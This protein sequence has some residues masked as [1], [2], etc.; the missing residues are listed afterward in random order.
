[1]ADEKITLLKHLSLLAMRCSAM[2]TSKIS[3][4][5]TAITED[6]IE[7]DEAKQDKITGTAGDKVVIGPDGNVTTEVS[8]DVSVETMTQAEYDALP[9]KD[10]NTLY[11]LTDAD[12]D[13]ASNVSV[14]T[15]TIGTAWTEDSETGVKS[16]TVAISGI[17][18]DHTAKVDCVFA[19]NKDSDGYA[20]FVEQQN[21]YLEFITNGYA[22]TVEGGITF[23][24][25]GDPNTV[26]IPIVVEV[27]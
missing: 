23:Y 13:S 11:L 7:L 20:A 4:L 27:V 3:E 5:T 6:L 2:V 26:S 16:Q 9:V 1:M 17:T 19:G 10:P 18:A 12:D 24:I 22:E 21:Q 25:F 8:D 15:A 14:Y